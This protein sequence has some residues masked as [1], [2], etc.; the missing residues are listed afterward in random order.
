ML[1]NMAV[2]FERQLAHSLTHSLT[3]SAQHAPA[4][5][6]TDRITGEESRWHGFAVREAE[7]ETE[8]AAQ[9]VPM[10]QDKP[11]TSILPVDNFLPAARKFGD[12]MYEKWSNQRSLS[13]NVRG[14][15]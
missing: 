3:G 1:R 5:L 8:T 12:E 4:W 11:T 9:Y 10:S 2:A 7:T 6:H 14:T 15:W 13:S